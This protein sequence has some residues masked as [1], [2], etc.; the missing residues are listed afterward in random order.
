MRCSERSVRAPGTKSAPVVGVRNHTSQYGLKEWIREF[1]GTR[2]L[3]GTCVLRL[4]PSESREH[5]YHVQAEVREGVTERLWLL[6]EMPVD[7][8]KP[9][10]P[11]RVKE[12]RYPDCIEVMSPLMAK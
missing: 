3:S 1:F 2:G 5:L 9:G 12:S 4:T 11:S 7:L 6:F 8:V 10:Q